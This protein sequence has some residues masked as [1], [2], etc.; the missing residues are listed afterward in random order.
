MKNNYMIVKNKPVLVHDA[1]CVECNLPFVY[2]IPRMGG[3]VYSPAGAKEVEINGRCEACFDNAF[4]EY[5]E[6]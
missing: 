5:Y 2:K 4:D 6:D 1:K 3:N